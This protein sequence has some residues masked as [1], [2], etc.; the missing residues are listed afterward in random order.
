MKEIQDRAYEIIQ[1]HSVTREELRNRLEREY[2]EDDVLIF[3]A[4]VGAY[5]MINYLLDNAG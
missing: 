1:D 5:Y 4:A 2:E 3:Y